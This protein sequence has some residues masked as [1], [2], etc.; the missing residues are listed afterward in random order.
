[1]KTCPFVR[2]LFFI[3]FYSF[4]LKITFA[5]HISTLYRFTFHLANAPVYPVRKHLEF[6]GR[7][8]PETEETDGT[9]VA[10]KEAQGN[11]P[12]RSGR[13]YARRSGR[14]YAGRCG[15]GFDGCSV[16]VGIFLTAI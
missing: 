15:R 4:P 10:G 12:G 2:R 13:H 11:D 3:P 6:A 16:P 7:S 5:N 9:G 14:A 1:M 8:L